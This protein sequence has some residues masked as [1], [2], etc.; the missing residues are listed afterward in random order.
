MRSKCVNGILVGLLLLAGCRKEDSTLDPV[1][2]IEV[3]SITPTSAQQYSDAVTVRI[4][5]RDN[6]GDLGENTAGVKN[7]FAVDNRIG[8][9]YEYR[10]SQLAPSGSAVPIEGEVDIDLGGQGILDSLAVEDRVT[11]AVTVVDRAGHQSNA[12]TT[13]EVRIIR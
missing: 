6:D 9:R 4:R 3:V 8:I 11:F 7:C 12:V 13:P 2:S 5:Y 10:I 1:P